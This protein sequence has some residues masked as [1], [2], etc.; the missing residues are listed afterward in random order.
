MRAR[1]IIPVIAIGLVMSL[2]AGC[3][4]IEIFE[5]TSN[6]NK[7]V[8]L[9]KDELENG[10]Y[11]VK[12]DTKFYAIHKLGMSSEGNDIDLSKCAWMVE[13]EKMLPE[14]YQNEL[15]AKSSTKIDKK[16]MVLE[17]FKDCGYSIGVY[18]ATYEDGYITLTT[19]N[20]L[21]PQSDA[22]K[23]LENDKSPNIMIET[24]NGVPVTENMIN[25]AGIITGF[26]KDASY[27][28]TFF[29][30]TSYGK[31]TITADTH[32]LQSFELYNVKDYEM[33]KN[34]YMAIHLPQDLESGYYRLDSEGF[35]KYY[36]FK[37]EEGDVAEVDYNIPYYASEEDQ[38][39]A[40][41]QQ[42]VF[43][44]DRN[45]SEMSVEAKFKPDSVTNISGKVKMMVTSPDGKRMTVE[46]AKEEG[47]IRCD[48]DLSMPGQWTVN[49]SPQSMT[50]ED[51]QLVS[52]TTSME[53]TKE[54][55]D[56]LFTEDQT[57]VIFELQYEGEGV[58]TAQLVDE[59]NNS[60]DLKGDQDI[61]L[62]GKTIH[63]MKYTCAYLPRGAYKVTV[64]H[65]PDTVI[66]SVDTYL[67]EA[68]KNVDIIEIE[69]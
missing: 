10:T 64:Y 44:L 65:Y 2:L 53:A 37:R 47:V 29:A 8:S 15:I 38:L 25:D 68:V 16:Q 19:N 34:G 4:D 5:D 36:N 49:I 57:G 52:N 21:V 32:F 67:S 7:A 26:D 48:M 12:R 3:G 41:S 39:A 69:E 35:F 51:V 31:T 58:V 27:E 59:N 54:N 22:K 23:K 30:G 33:T 24:I 14:Y 55:Y 11:Y 46:T 20:N 50:V 40:F 60:Y 63:T 61:K 62:G 45:T 1:K 6:K 18:G 56:M 42:Y 43:N 9:N 28:I 66:T 17:R 13:D